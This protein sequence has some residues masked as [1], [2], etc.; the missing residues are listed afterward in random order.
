MKREQ[1]TFDSTNDLPDQVLSKLRTITPPD[2]IITPEILTGLRAGDHECY[3]T[4][5]LHWR[6]P[7]YRFVFNLT[8]SETEADDMTQDIFTALWNYR[9]N[10]DPER[11]IR[12]FLFLLARRSVADKRRSEEIHQRYADS[13]WLD[14]TDLSTSYDMVVEK[15]AELLKKVLLE[16]MPPQQKLIFEMA[17]DQGLNTDEIAEKLDIKKETVYNQLY[18][19]RKQIRD[20]ILL[21]LIIFGSVSNDTIRKIIDSLLN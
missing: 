2:H 18:K 12:S 14:E 11:N 17:H 6:K 21:L 15:E 19:A 16:R 4:V 3:K 8:G 20:S 7:I 9:E 1:N 5:Y 13:L 10:I